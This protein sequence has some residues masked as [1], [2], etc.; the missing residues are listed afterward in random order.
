MVQ[1]GS[2]TINCPAKGVP[3][4][5]ITWYRYKDGIEVELTDFR[6]VEISEDGKE[7]TILEAK[8]DDSA[9][10]TCKAKNEAGQ[11]EISYNVDVQGRSLS[12][13]L[14]LT[15]TGQL[16]QHKPNLAK[17]YNLA[18]KTHPK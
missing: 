4:P 13:K 1:D 5:I 10:Y 15:N 17:A 2:L 16:G 6:N 7:L 18:N 8:E 11:S 14:K 9:R 3:P 12:L